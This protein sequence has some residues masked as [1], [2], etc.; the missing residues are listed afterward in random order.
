[1]LESHI[2]VRASVE[3]YRRQWEPPSDLVKLPEDPGEGPDWVIAA[4]KAEQVSGECL[5]L[6]GVGRWFAAQGPRVI[7]VDKVD[8]VSHHDHEITWIVGDSSSLDVAAQVRALVGADRCMVVLDSD[9]SAQH[10]AA[11]I[12]LY[13]PLVSPS[14]HLVVEDGI[15]RWMDDPLFVNGGPLE[16]VEELLADDDRLA[17]RPHGRV[18]V[19][20]IHAPLWMVASPVEVP[21]MG[22]SPRWEVG[23]QNIGHRP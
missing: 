21:P 3:S 7:T 16:A 5:V 13:G 14:C 17:P 12:K 15:V 19:Q 4:D 22:R 20:R 9:H 18:H 11:E 23:T 8:N 6:R 1:M 10:V 2:D